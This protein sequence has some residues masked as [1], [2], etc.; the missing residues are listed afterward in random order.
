LRMEDFLPVRE[1]PVRLPF[2]GGL[3]GQAISENGWRQYCTNAG[4]G[5]LSV[6]PPCQSVAARYHG[7][8]DWYIG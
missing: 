4:S 3:G 7:W 1:S 8:F 2:S 5:L 6:I